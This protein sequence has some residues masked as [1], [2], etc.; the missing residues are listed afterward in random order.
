MTPKEIE[1]RIRADNQVKASFA[2]DNL[3]F[4]PETAYIHDLHNQGKITGEQ[5][6]SMFKAYYTNLKIDQ[7]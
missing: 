5:A 4:N 2:V 7:G 1:A 6:M 3:T